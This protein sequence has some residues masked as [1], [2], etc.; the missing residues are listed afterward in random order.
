M[1][2]EDTTEADVENPT[3]STQTVATYS[4]K[5][6]EINDSYYSRSLMVFGSS[7]GFT[8]TFMNSAF[9]NGTYL[10]DL[11]L[12][13]TGNDGS[14][15]SVTTQRVETNVMD[16]TATRSTMDMWGIILAG[17]LPVAILAAGLVIFLKRRHL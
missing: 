15:V 2:T 10:T 1:I 17:I 4:Y 7:N 8:D 9:D 5:S 3:T 13:A 6:V 12:F 16:I 14:N 11:V